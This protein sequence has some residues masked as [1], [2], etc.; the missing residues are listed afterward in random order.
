MTVPEVTVGRPGRARYVIVSDEPGKPLVIRD[1]G[2]WDRHP[3]VTN[4]V[5]GVVADLAA[6][7]KLSACSKCGRP[8]VDGWPGCFSLKEGHDCDGEASCRR[9]LYF[10]SDGELDEIVVRGGKFVGFKPCLGAPVGDPPDALAMIRRS[11]ADSAARATNGQG[12]TEGKGHE[13]QPR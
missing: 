4:D 2:P 13:G 3:T 7:G 11:D 12:D 9:L 1:V 6:K 8:W 5:D 10:D